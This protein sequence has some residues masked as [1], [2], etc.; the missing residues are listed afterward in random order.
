MSDAFA[1]PQSKIRV[2]SQV[3]GGGFGGKED[4]TF[5]VSVIAGV[6]AIKTQRPVYYELTRDEV[7]KNTGK[8]HPSHI[9]HILAAKKDGTVTGIKVEAFV[10]KGAYKSIDAIPSRIVQY[11]G[12]PYA[13][14]NA[15]CHSVSVFTDHPYGCAFR[16]LGSPQAHFAMECQMDE[17]AQRLSMDGGTEKKEYAEGRRYNNMEP[18]YA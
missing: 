10:D 1:M 13:I 14:A 17:L 16:G 8:R 3:V 7:F 15:Y 5:D 2:I 18:A 12:G 11:A 4:S 9:H 6:L